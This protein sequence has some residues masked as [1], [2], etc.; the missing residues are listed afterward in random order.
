MASP[1]AVPRAS[2]F[3]W[4]RPASWRWALLAPLLAL[5]IGAALLWLAG[6]DQVTGQ[7]LMLTKRPLALHNRQSL[8]Q[9]FQP[10]VNGLHQVDIFFDSRGEVRSRQV[11]FILYGSDGLPLVNE[12]VDAVDLRDSWYPFAF[13]PI[14]GVAGQQLRIDLRRNAPARD[15]IGVWV[16]PGGSYPNGYGTIDNVPDPSFDIAFR[17]YHATEP[18]FGARAA[19]VTAM[20]NAIAAGRPGLAGQPGTL[21]ALGGLYAAGLAALMMVGV[22][23]PRWRA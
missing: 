10:P 13:A 5:V 9:T 6:A 2:R 12:E 3:A 21:L 11:R 7:P 18:T 19:R 20:A 23:S 22:A 8:G 15:S 17:A 16:G 4:R 1:P 14:S